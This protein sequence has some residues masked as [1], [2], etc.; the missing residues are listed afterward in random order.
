MSNKIGRKINKAKKKA[1]KMGEKAAVNVGQVVANE[2][3]VQVQV[4]KALRENPSTENLG[5]TLVTTGR[6][7]KHLGRSLKAVGRGD[8]EGAESQGEKALNKAKKIDLE[9]AALAGAELE[10]IF[11]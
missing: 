6:T 4:G 7:Q 2:G 11:A 1:K 3:T 5:E 10:L 8:M 9:K